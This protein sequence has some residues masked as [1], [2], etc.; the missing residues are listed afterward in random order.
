MSALMQAAVRPAA[1][2]GMFYSADCAELSAQ[3]DELLGAAADERNQPAP[4][5]I[6][7]PHAGYMYSGE[8]AARA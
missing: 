8:T 3:V 5:A 6:I 1:V 2:A 7:V 4:K